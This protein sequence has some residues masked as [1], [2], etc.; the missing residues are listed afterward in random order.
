MIDNETAETAQKTSSDIKF[1]Y[2][3]RARNNQTINRIL[4]GCI[5]VGPL[6]AL[7]LVTGVFFDITYTDCVLISGIEAML[8]FIHLLLYKKWPASKVTSY[9]CLLFMDC[10]IFY[11]SYLHVSI[12]ISYFIVP[13]LSLFYCDNSFRCY[14]NSYNL[15]LKRL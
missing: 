14:R 10:L 15:V 12:H 5:V 13:L 6:L 1:L 7:G 9:F 11:M 2:I 3:N 4:W 8:A